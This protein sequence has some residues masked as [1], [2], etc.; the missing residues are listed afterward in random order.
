MTKPTL[1]L[2]ED[3]DPP[4]GAGADH[5]D[6]VSLLT[7]HQGSLRAYLVSLMP[8][9]PQVNDVLQET[10][11]TLWKKRESF[12]LG[13]NFTAWSFAVA[14]FS[15]KEHRARHYRDQRRLVF[16]DALLE[17]V[18]LTPDEAAPDE[19]DGRHGALER[20]LGKLPEADRAIVNARYTKGTNLEEHALE[21]G[22]SAGSLRV[23]LF[24]IRAALRKCIRRQLSQP[25]SLPPR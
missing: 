20:C 22:R 4:R 3:P 15:V 10:N 12:Q 23:A 19:L 25:P 17:I 5:E 13:S 8:G 18:S 11:I 7:R 24:R 14:R 1:R 2:V 9:D 21:V 6:F 16:S